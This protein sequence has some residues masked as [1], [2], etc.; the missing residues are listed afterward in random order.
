MLWCSS[1]VRGS[2]AASVWN[3]HMCV[4]YDIK[5]FTEIRSLTQVTMYV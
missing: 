1:A 5:C 3:M 4:W 2:V